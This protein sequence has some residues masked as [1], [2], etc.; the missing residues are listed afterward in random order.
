LKINPAEIEAKMRAAP[1]SYKSIRA[2][3]MV[4]FE[5]YVTQI[6]IRALDQQGNVTLV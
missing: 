6:E 2:V 1:D 3:E 5:K 4:V